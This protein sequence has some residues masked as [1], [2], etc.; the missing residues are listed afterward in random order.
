ML[1]LALPPEGGLGSDYCFKAILL[2]LHTECDAEAPQ[3]RR[4]LSQLFEELNRRNELIILSVK[5]VVH[6][7]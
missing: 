6:V 3:A 7:S 5:F 1:L 4:I 2:H